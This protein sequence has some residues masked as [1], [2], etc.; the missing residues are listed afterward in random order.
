MLRVY[1]DKRQWSATRSSSTVDAEGEELQTVQG[2][3]IKS[4]RKKR[5]LSNR[6]SS[7]LVDG[8]SGLE[9]SNSLLDPDNQS[10]MGQGSSTI[11]TD[12]DDCQSQRNS[13]GDNRELLGMEKLGEDDKGAYSFIH[14]RALSRL[15]PARQKKFLWSEEAER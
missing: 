9:A 15:N 1:Y 2:K 6:I 5:R 14:K 7:K 11:T 8:H 3:R 13:A 12:D 4:P 10:T